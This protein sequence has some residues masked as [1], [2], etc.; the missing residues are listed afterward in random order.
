MS[1]V[2]SGPHLAVRALRS[3][4]L[5]RRVQQMDRFDVFYQAYV[6]A[7]VVGIAVLVV[8]EW[9]AGP[10]VDARPLVL[11]ANGS[12]VLGLLAAGAIAAGIRS[13]SRGGPLTLEAPDVRHIVLSPVPKAISLRAPALRQ[14]RFL[15]GAAAAIGAAAGQ[16][17]SHRLPGHA[18]AWTVTG[19]IW[20]TL[21]VVSAVAAGWMAAGRRAPKAVATGAA[22]LLLACAAAEV[23]GVLP[24]APTHWFGALGMLPVRVDFVAVLLVPIVTVVAAATGLAGLAGSSVEQLTRRSSLVGELRFAAT[25]QD[26]RTV[27][28]LRRQLHQEH[29]RSTPWLPTRRRGG[30]TIVVARDWRAL[31][32]TPLPRLLRMVALTAGSSAAAVGAWHGTPALIVV[33]GLCAFLLGLEV[34]EPLAQETDRCTILELAPV[35]RGQILAQHLIVPAFAAAVLAA[36]A[37]ACLLPLTH[38]AGSRT[39]IVTVALVAP[40]AAVAGAAIN[41][42]RDATGPGAQA[43]EQLMLPPEAVGMRLIYRMAF[44]PAVSTA[45]FLPV[46]M[47]SR[48]ADAGTDPATA[49]TSAGVAVVALAVAVAVW[50]RHR[51]GLRA[52][53]AEATSAPAVTGA[54]T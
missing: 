2:E 26:L 50:V 16:M 6:T 34:L 52:Q 31:K 48:A 19:A 42:L 28:L 11:V 40:L 38:S 5:A 29:V 53:L 30:R 14:A 44:P 10:A 3:R 15:A 45:G 12:A 32:R 24:V 47:A 22:A 36:T 49:A 41:V 7:I 25:M 13:G 1:T 51:D 43:I 18:L 17:A 37:A 33:A 46:F 54:A 8:S 9:T 27:M 21:T 39:V 23:A 4:R 20:A 35:D